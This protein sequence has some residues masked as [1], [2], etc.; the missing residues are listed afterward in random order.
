L[1]IRWK[2][3]AAAA[4]ATTIDESPGAHEKSVTKCAEGNLALV[5]D[6]FAAVINS[7]VG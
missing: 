7:A 2:I 1:G 5:T 6:S 4:G 3:R